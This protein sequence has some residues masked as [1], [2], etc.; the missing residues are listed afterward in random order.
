M[1]FFDAPA[2]VGYSYS[3]SPETYQYG[4]ENSPKDLFYA[5]QDFLSHN[6][7]LSNLS[8]YIAGE[9][10]AGKYIPDLANKIYSYN[11]MNP[12]SQINLKGMFIINGILNQETFDSSQVKYMISH[13]FIDPKLIPYWENSCAND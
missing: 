11:L 2:D 13:N 5:L 9:S 3:E 10:F 8:F 12:D 7:Q 6:S 1:L 4:D